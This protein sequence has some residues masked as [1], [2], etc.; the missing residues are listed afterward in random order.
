LFVSVLSDSWASPT[1]DNRTRA[2]PHAHRH[3]VQCLNQEHHAAARGPHPRSHGS[4]FRGGCRRWGSA[5]WGVGRL[6]RAGCVV[7]RE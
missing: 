7:T 5:G 2:V 3:T 1:I 4:C 6:G